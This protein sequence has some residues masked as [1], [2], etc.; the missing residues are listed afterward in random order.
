MI[1]LYE[2][3]KDGIETHIS[4]LQLK[5]VG[6]YIIP[7]F[8]DNTYIVFWERTYIDAWDAEGNLHKI[9]NGCKDVFVRYSDEYIIE[10]PSCLPGDIRMSEI[11]CKNKVYTS[12][13][14]KW[15]TFSHHDNEALK[16]L[17]LKE[18]VDYFGSSDESIDRFYHLSDFS[19]FPF[20]EKLVSSYDGKG[21]Y[22]RIVPHREALLMKDV[23]CPILKKCVSRYDTMLKKAELMCKSLGN[24]IN[25]IEDKYLIKTQKI[26]EDKMHYFWEIDFN[27]F[28]LNNQK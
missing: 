13:F 23:K 2:M 16:C 5:V 19:K 1:R 9:Q 8:R 25:T 28:C 4:S 15:N 27:N 3:P 21:G 17:G 24:L 22:Y 6:D 12:I 18:G 7:S 26:I 10:N 20:I 11:I 14:R